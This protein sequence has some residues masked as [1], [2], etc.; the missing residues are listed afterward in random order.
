M[1]DAYNLPNPAK[2]SDLAAYLLLSGGIM[3]G[4]VTFNNNLGLSWKNTTGSVLLQA[5]FNDNNNFV[6]GNTSNSQLVI[7][8]VYTHVKPQSLVENKIL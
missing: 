6:I 1:W 2:I 4:N 5:Y 8:T 7:R 3:T